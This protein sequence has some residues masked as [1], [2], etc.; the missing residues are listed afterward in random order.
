MPYANRAAQAALLLATLLPTAL[1]WPTRAVAQFLEEATSS[2]TATTLGD[3]RLQRYRV[4]VVVTA[5]GGPCRGLYATTPVPAEWPEQQVR[6]VSEDFSPAVRSV[7]YRMLADGVKQMIISVPLL[8]AGEEARAVV[9]YELDRAAILPPTDPTS[10][11]VPKKLDRSLRIFLQPSPYIESRHG[12]I[13]RFAR[14]AAADLD[15]WAKVEAIYDAVREKVVYTN[16]DLKGAAR[17][18]ADG[19]GDCE[20]LTCLFIAACRSQGVPARTVW[21]EGHCYPEFYLVD[22]DGNGLW[23]PCQA[24]GTRAFGSMPDQ[25]P[26]LQ[27]GD[28]FRDPDRP[29]KQLRYVSEFVTGSAVGGGGKPH[30]QYIREGG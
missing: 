18:L 28:N 24:A 2:A 27:K 21:V 26:I 11:E 29:T 5:V 17:A 6:V 15:G 16:G 4:G 30:V 22:S 12:G 3:R 9:T 10:L 19:E 1:G 13:V 23:Y 25:L 20:E 14:D 8:E 7:R